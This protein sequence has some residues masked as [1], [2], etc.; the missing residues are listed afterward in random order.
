[1][2]T[3]NPKPGQPPD[4]RPPSK[5]QPTPENGDSPIQTIDL[6][7]KD[8]RAYGTFTLP[9]LPNGKV[10]WRRPVYENGRGDKVWVSA[11]VHRPLPPLE[12]KPATLTLKHVPA[13][14]P[15][16]LT[17]TV[18]LT[19]VDPD[20]DANKLSVGVQSLFEEQTRTVDA[21]GTA[22]ITLLYKKFGMSIKV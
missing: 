20:G 19:I 15:L 7:I 5:V 8:T 3:G 10:Y 6:L 4:H 9:P 22:G 2:W 12:H 14:R 17:S 11:G 1:F 18:G 13:K 21:A 16:S